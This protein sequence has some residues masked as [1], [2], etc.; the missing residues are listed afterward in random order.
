MSVLKAVVLGCLALPF[1]HA[2]PRPFQAGP[3]AVVPGLSSTASNGTCPAPVTEFTTAQVPSPFKPFNQDELDALV[4]WLHAPERNLNLTKAEDPNLAMSDNYIYH[5]EEL[6]PNKTDVLAYLDNGIP[7]PRY[8]R[9]TMHEGAKQVPV[10]TDYFIG[11]LPI[12]DETAIQP[13]D[14]FYNGVNG[15]RI[16][17]NGA[18]SAGPRAAAIEAFITREMTAL[19]DITQ[20]VLGM[21]YFGEE[22]ERS[23]LSYFVTNPFSKDGTQA[24][25]WSSWRRAGLAPYSQPTDLNIRWDIGGTDPS[26]YKLNMVVYNNKVYHSAEELRTAWKN[27]QIEKRPFLSADNSYIYKDR[28]GPVRALENRMAPTTVEPDGKRYKV[29][30]KNKYIEYLGWKFYTRFDSDIGL[31]FYDVKF[32]NERILYELSMQDAIA[33]Y[34]GNN[35]FQA[36]TAYMDRHYG[37]GGLLNRLVPGYDC[38]YHATYLNADFSY[39]LKAV[40]TNNSIC[41]FEADIGTP[42]TRHFEPSVPGSAKGYLQSTKG[43]KLVVRQI[44]TVGNYD[45]LWDY[46]FYVDGTITIDAHASGYVQATYYRPEDGGQWGPRLQESIQ[47]TLHTHVMNFKADFD[48][49]DTANTFVKTDIVVENVTKE[50]APELGEFEMMRYNFTTIETEAQGLLPG[51]SNGQTMY[52]VENTAKLNK[53]GVPRGYRIVPGLSNVGLTSQTNPFFLKSGQFAKQPFAVSRQHDTEPAASAAMNQNV[54]HA[55]LVEFW[56]FFEDGEDLVQQDI[57]A[58]VNLGMQHYTRSE[59]MPN[60]LMSEAHSSIMFAPQ[61]WGEAELTV[62]LQNAIIYNGND[63]EGPLQPETNGVS[64]PVCFPLGNQDGLLGVWEGVAA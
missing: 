14:Y 36:S 60:T 52:T 44:A 58:W 59:D 16:L 50:W 32:K 31:Q 41:I 1:V 11:P 17:F 21:A 18:I 47:G 12:C 43:S 62:D 2:A 29:D 25:A 55:P 7:M 30:A 51:I 49:I 48:L 15:P 40:T 37:I 24:L 38:P 34:A 33:Q 9:I 27:G 57:V 3:R 45:Y 54:P 64:P 19:A 13:L 6:K 56:K 63:G 39:L 28:K 5:I 53:W 61:N 20:D 23:T 35:P 8:A 10:V 26:L 46:A 42:I 22:D 4:A